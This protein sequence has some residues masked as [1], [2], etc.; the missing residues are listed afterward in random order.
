MLN[1]IEGKVLE[2]FR[3]HATICSMGKSWS[4]SGGH[5]TICS[6]GKFY[7][8]DL[9]PL[10]GACHNMFYGKVL[11][12]HNMLYGKALEV[13]R[14]NIFNGKGAIIFYREGGGR[15]SV[16]AGR[17][18]FL[19]PPL[20]CAKKFWS[21]PRHARKNSGPPLAYAKKFWSPPPS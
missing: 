3:G 1:L 8:K 4:H 20:A 18:F 11:A 21:P 15:L 13:A 5:A 7:C 14:D 9:E 19:V 10:R 17:Q 6:M 16:I 12:C 2:P